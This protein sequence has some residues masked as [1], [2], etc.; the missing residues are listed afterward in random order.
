MDLLYTSYVRKKADKQTNRFLKMNFN[1]FFIH[2]NG[3]VGGG[4]GGLFC[5]LLL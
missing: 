3:G 1:D 5:V 2:F 4:G